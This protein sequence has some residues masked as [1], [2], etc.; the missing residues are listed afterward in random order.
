MNAVLNIL[1]Q[2]VEHRQRSGFQPSAYSDLLFL[3]ISAQEDLV[4]TVLFYPAVEQ[5]GIFY[6]NAADGSHGCTTFKYDLQVV[7]CFNATAKVYYQRGFARDSLQYFPVHYCAFLSAVQ[8]Y[9]VQTLYAYILKGFGYFQRML[10]IYF[11]LRIIALRKAHAF[12]ANDVD[13]GDHCKTFFFTH[14]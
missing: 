6:S 14:G 4:C 1:L 11:L 8:V 10:V 5:L 3:H 9:Q 7:R 12:T 13:G 2:K